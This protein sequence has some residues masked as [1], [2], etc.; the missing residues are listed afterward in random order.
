MEWAAKH[1]REMGKRRPST[2]CA[3]ERVQ[4]YEMRKTS[5]L[6]RYDTLS[7]DK[8]TRFDAAWQG[9]WCGL[10]WSLAVGVVCFP[11]QKPGTPS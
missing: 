2:T 8:D 10:I 9:M 1:V 7:I 11:P 5:L 6:M 3:E 4:V